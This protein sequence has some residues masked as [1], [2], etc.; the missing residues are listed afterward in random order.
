MGEGE[1]ARPVPLPDADGRDA[2]VTRLIGTA[3]EALGAAG[4]SVLLVE[5]GTCTVA[6]ATAAGLLD[7]EATQCACGRGPGVQ[8]LR[9]GEAVV[10]ADVRGRRGEWPEYADAAV[11]QGFSA[12]A[13]IPMR[14]GEAV[15]GV[16][17]VFAAR[18]W[19]ASE[20]AVGASLAGMAA[21]HLLT[22]DRLRHQERVTA[23]LRHALSS[24]IVVEQAKGVLAGTRRI[25]PEAAY[26]LIRA[27]A[28]RRRIGVHEVARAIVE[29]GLRP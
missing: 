5:D 11:G 21:G 16:L 3:T 19:T 12:V 23:Q 10:A 25:T 28:R 7:L 27:H 18:A 9:R 14:W 8:A 13:A 29:H 17:G 20:V 22:A 2:V 1:R 26:E 4:A 6:A 15:L 24:R